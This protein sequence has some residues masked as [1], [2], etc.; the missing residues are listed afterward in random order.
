MSQFNISLLAKQGWRIINNQNSLVMRVLKAKYFPND[1]F[2]NSRLGNSSTNISIH[3]D[4]WVP[5]AIN[6]RL[7]SE[8]NSMRDSKVN[9]LIDN[10][11]R[12][13]RIELIKNTFAE[14]DAVRILRI[15]LAC[16]PH[17]DFLV[18]GGEA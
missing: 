18:W 12:K 11:E 4:S 6:F 7:S 9:A 10:I 1:Q 17:D 2:L 15:P 14:E 16:V 5:D 3:D 13:W 8:V